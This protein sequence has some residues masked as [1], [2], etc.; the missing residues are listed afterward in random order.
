MI[1]S[2]AA[3]SP[4]AEAGLMVGD[5]VTALDQNAI[6]AVE[7]LQRLLSAL[8]IGSETSLSFARGGEIH[9]SRVLVGAQ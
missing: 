3:D 6:E 9:L 7:Q 8:E 1:V 2:V 4:A 5:I